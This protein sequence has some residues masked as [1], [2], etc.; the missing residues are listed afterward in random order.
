MSSAENNQRNEQESHALVSRSGLNVLGYNV[1]WWVVVVVIVLVTYVLYDRGYL[2]GVF[3]TKTVSLRNANLQ[4]DSVKIPE[5][6][7]ELKKMMM[8][9]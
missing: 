7:K 1:P 5:G 6:V 4:I 8:G 9:Y 2:S 3:G